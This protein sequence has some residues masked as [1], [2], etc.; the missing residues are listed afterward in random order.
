LHN[1]R[2]VIVFRDLKPANIIL[3]RDGH[4]FLIDFGI[5]R[6]YKPGQIR[7]TIPFGSPGYAAPEQ[8]GKAQ[9]TP[10]AD[11]YSLGA[12]LHQ[13]LSG[14][15][16]SQ[17]PFSFAPLVDQHYP[18]RAALHALTQRM[19]HTDPRLRPNDISIVKRELQMIATQY[20]S[21]RG[22]YSGKTPMPFPY[23]NLVPFNPSPAHP[24]P[25]QATSIWSTGMQPTVANA[26]MAGQLRLVQSYPYRQSQHKQRQQQQSTAK[27]NGYALAS[28]ISGLL[29][30]FMPL[31]LCSVVSASIGTRSPSPLIV[32]LAILLLLP[33]AMGIIFGYIGRHDARK[34]SG[35]RSGIEV[36]NAGITLGFAFG[37][38]YL[39][40]L[41]FMLLFTWYAR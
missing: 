16:P 20:T 40:F 5:A 17:A 26:A 28:L 6:H 34:Q 30:V 27:I 1:H 13:L 35:K 36:A 25:T 15:D 3:T 41:L 18:E 4:L 8:Y 39:L 21:Q 9:T 24:Q 19:V 31:F 7:D 29:G 23:R 11:I 14:D 10:L 22:L 32:L 12:I 33:S 37:A 38:I 2:P